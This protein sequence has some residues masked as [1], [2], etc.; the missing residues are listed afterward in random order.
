MYVLAFACGCK[1]QSESKKQIPAPTLRWAGNALILSGSAVGQVGFSF[2]GVELTA[3]AAGLPEDSVLAFG[4]KR[5]RV[6]GGGVA[7][8]A[9]ITAVLADLNAA[10]VLA[11]DFAFGS[12]TTSS[13]PMIRSARSGS[14]SGWT[15]C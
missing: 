4:G 11:P 9:D 13:C 7:V 10:A 1:A 14:L 3:T 2:S 12:R 5:E 15:R 8:T 6:K